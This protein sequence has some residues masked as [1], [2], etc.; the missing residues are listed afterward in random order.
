MQR[1]TNPT[2]R[3]PSKAHKPIWEQI[4]LGSA[5]IIKGTM[6][7]L[8]AAWVK[9]LVRRLQRK[10]IEYKLEKEREKNVG[11]TSDNSNSIITLPY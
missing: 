7:K 2:L 5:C 3:V 11:H 4:F 6:N 8:S 10:Q 1:S 9:P